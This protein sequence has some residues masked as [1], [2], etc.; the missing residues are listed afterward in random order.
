MAYPHLTL[1]DDIG[2]VSAQHPITL[3]RLRAINAR[4]AANASDGSAQSSSSA[5]ND[6]N[7]SA[8]VASDQPSHSSSSAANDSD[9]PPELANGSDEPPQSFDSNDSDSDSSSEDFDSSS[10][11]EADLDAALQ[12]DDPIQPASSQ[13]VAHIMSELQA[14][15]DRSVQIEVSASALNAQRPAKE[16][17]QLAEGLE[18]IRKIYSAWSKYPPMGGAIDGAVISLTDYTNAAVLAVKGAK[19]HSLSRRIARFM[20][21]TIDPSKAE[22][23]DVGTLIHEQRRIDNCMLT[24][25]Q[26]YAIWK[27]QLQPDLPLIGDEL[28]QELT[29]DAAAPITYTMQPPHGELSAPSK[30]ADFFAASNFAAMA[31]DEA[32]DSMQI[33][34]SGKILETKAEKASDLAG[35]IAAAKVAEAKEAKETRAAEAEALKASKA[36]KGRAGKKSAFAASSD[37]EEGDEII[38]S[39]SA[40]KASKATPHKRAASALD[41]DDDDLANETGKGKKKAV[42]RKRTKISEDMVVSSDDDNDAQAFDADDADGGKVSKKTARPGKSAQNNDVADEPNENDES[43]DESSSSSE[44]DSSGPPPPIGTVAPD[45]RQRG[46]AAPKWLHDEDNLGRQII[47]DNPKMPMPAVWRRFNIELANTAFKTDKM[48]THDYRSDWI[49]S[50]R[51]DSNGIRINDKKARKLDICH[52]SYESL[53]QHL[54]KHKARVNDKSKPQPVTWEEC[55]KNPVSHLPKRAPPPRPTYFSDGRTLVDPLTTSRRPGHSNNGTSG[56]SSAPSGYGDNAPT[57][58]FNGKQYFQS[59]GWAAIN[60]PVSGNFSPIGSSPS[61]QPKRKREAKG[62]GMAELSQLSSS[63][64]PGSSKFMQP[65]NDSGHP[66]S[67]ADENDSWMANLPLAKNFARKSEVPETL[68]D[69]VTDQSDDEEGHD[70]EQT[71]VQRP[72]QS[73]FDYAHTYGQASGQADDES[74]DDNYTYDQSFGSAS[75]ARGNRGAGV[76]RAPASWTQ[77]SRNP[78]ASRASASSTRVSRGAGVTKA[79]GSSTRGSRSGRTARSIKSLIVRLKVRTSRQMSLEDQAVFRAA[80]IKLSQSTAP[81]PHPPTTADSPLAYLFHDRFPSAKRPAEGAGLTNALLATTAP[82]LAAALLPQPADGVDRLSQTGSKGDDKGNTN[83][84]MTGQHRNEGEA[85]AEEQNE[86]ST[87]EREHS[88]GEVTVADIDEDKMSEDVVEKDNAMSDA[89]IDSDEEA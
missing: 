85:T 63:P 65:Q 67:D 21:K 86:Q 64:Y 18:A 44:D 32:H 69:F 66:R 59:S 10:D 25:K 27:T 42:S 16:S 53:R 48:A 23:E 11:P 72:N 1:P 31:E 30:P 8:E 81:P 40:R 7:S 71:Q 24:M 87:A 33:F 55:T 77:G 84:N 88:D 29:S 68:E 51:V 14:Q 61:E 5:A 22:G 17:A 45:K 41:A 83:A 36:A 26:Q 76:P 13:F 54:E 82:A 6:K 62:K 89:P 56:L 2:E 34:V 60:N 35:R 12:E 38:P 37:V 20:A 15:L 58:T 79:R 9:S 39:R 57:S 74:E 73:L 52:R 3:D 47:Q 19:T 75:S 49:P 50:P 4:A 28:V 80:L 43:S 78:A 46:G 70:D